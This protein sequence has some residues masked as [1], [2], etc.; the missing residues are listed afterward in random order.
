MYFFLDSVPKKKAFSIEDQIATDENGRRRFHGAFTGGFS[1]G[2]F[3][4]VGS[5]EG[6]TPSEFKSSRSDK[7]EKKLQKPEDFM[8]SEDVGAFGIAPKL[9]KATSDYSNTTKRKR[10][11]NTKGPIPGVPVLHSLLQPAKETIG[12]RLLKSMGWK[13]GQGVGPRLT[14]TQKLKARREHKKNIGKVYGCEVPKEFKKDFKSDTESSSDEDTDITFAPD[15][16]D[17]FI[18]EPKINTF[19][20]GYSGLSKDSILGSHISLFDP[21]EFRMQERNNKKV[22]ISGQAFG[23][24]AFEDEDDDIYLRDDMSKYDFELEAVTKKNKLTIKGKE[25]DKLYDILEGFERA[26]CKS[27]SKKTYPPPTLPKGFI[28]KHGARIS[29]FE[30]LP[31][32]HKFYKYDRTKF[33]GRHDLT[34]TDRSKI[35]NSEH[36]VINKSDHFKS[37]NTEN[38]HSK[39]LLTN[40]NSQE[41]E[42]TDK[43]ILLEKAKKI[44]E[45]LPPS[46]SGNFKPFINDSEKQKRYEQY[47]CLMKTNEKDKL[48]DI[49]PVNMS[50]WEK[51]HEKNEFE[52]A[53]RLF[54]P[55]IGLVFDRFVSAS[56]SASDLD[57]LQPVTKSIYEHGTPEMREAAKK[58]MF[59]HL[60]HVELPWTPHKL[61]CRRMNIPEPNQM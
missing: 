61:L 53:A 28:A 55:V 3:N 21:P 30:P 11:L 24:G 17:A 10:I 26:K 9:V 42:T 15:D 57:P 13:P 52:Q 45:S 22:S 56:N 46:S 47:M 14:K 5:L 20:M 59:G 49:Q 16:Y 44:T 58:K 36:T 38:Y 1:A 4:T 29:R 7:A 40:N 6:W 2:F 33:M 54:K 23:V 43:I 35:I 25:V 39:N 12:I 31:E 8:D 50:E 60:T 48:S 27:L 34:A 37:E 19:G 51:E 32:T 18:Y 41:L